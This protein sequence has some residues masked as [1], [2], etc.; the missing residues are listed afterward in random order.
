MRIKQ[1]TIHGNLS[2]MKNKNSPNLF[3]KETVDAV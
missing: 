1:M 2:E 3:Y